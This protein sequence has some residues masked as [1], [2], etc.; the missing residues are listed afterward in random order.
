MT[1]I[2][3]GKFQ[4]SGVKRAEAVGRIRRDEYKG[5]CTILY[6]ST[7]L[8]RYFVALSS[9]IFDEVKKVDKI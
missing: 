8:A 1:A 2:P 6:Y 7:E 5:T 9:A 3:I 4:K